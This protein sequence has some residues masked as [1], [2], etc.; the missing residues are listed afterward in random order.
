[1]ERIYFIVLKQKKRKE[2]KRN[3]SNDMLITRILM[4]ATDILFVIIRQSQG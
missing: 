2:K 1:M 3:E 4:W